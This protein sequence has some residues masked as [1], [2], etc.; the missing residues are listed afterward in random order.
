MVNRELKRAWAEIHLDRLVKNVEECRSLIKEP[1]ELMCVVKA[2]CYGHGIEEIIPCL[3]NVCGVKHFAVS[4]IVEAT[5][6]RDLGVDGDILILGYTPPENAG[7]LCSYNLIQTITDSDYAKKLSEH[8]P[9]GKKV[10]AHIAVDTGMTRI[11]IRSGSA[12]EMCDEIEFIASLEGISIG[13]V[14]THYSAADSES[15]DDIKYTERQTETILA[16]GEELKKRGV[17]I[18]YIHFLNSAGAAYH[19]NSKSAFARFGIMLYGLHPS[20]DMKLPVALGQVME[21]KACV[22]QVKTV[23]AGA[24]VSYGRSFVTQ[25]E[26]VIASVTIGYADGYPRLLSNRASVLVKGRRA[27]IIGRICMDQLMID[28]SGIDGVRAGDTVTL[29]GTDGDEKITADELASMYGTIGYEIVCG[30]SARVPRIFIN[31]PKNI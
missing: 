15:P 9:G 1:C 6:L 21:L 22:S 10:K 8:C 23:E 25:K 19:F 13:G 31:K 18:P 16:V 27:R 30:I 29:I 2:N 11:G 12:E 26:T 3:Q 17:N 5:E 24:Y 7:E 28:V 14:F 4:N 20:P